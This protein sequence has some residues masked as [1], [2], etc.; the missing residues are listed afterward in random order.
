[1]NSC[2][3]LVIKLKELILLYDPEDC[4]GFNRL[5]KWRKAMISDGFPA[6]V[7]NDWCVAFLLTPLEDLTSRDVDAIVD[8]SSRSLQL[9]ASASQ[10]IAQT[11]FPKEGFEVKNG[12]GIKQGKIKERVRLARL[13]GEFINILRGRKPEENSKDAVV[14]DIVLDACSE[15]CSS[16]ED[17]GTKRNDLYK[18]HGLKLKSL[19]TE[20][21]GKRRSREDGKEIIQ[22]SVSTP[23]T[24]DGEL[25]VVKFVSRQTSYLH[26]NLPFVLSH[27]ELYAPMLML[28]RRWLSSIVTKPVLASHTLEIVE[29]LFSDPPSDSNSHFLEQV[30]GKIQERILSLPKNQSL[31]AQ[32]QAA[33]YN[34]ESKAELDLWSSPAVELPCYLSRRESP[35]ERLHTKKLTGVLR[36]LWYE[37]KDI[38]F[39]YLVPSVEVGGKEV[40]TKDLFGFQDSLKEMEEQVVAVKAKVEQINSV[41]V[42]SEDLERR[43]KRLI[44][45][46]QQH[47]KRIEKIYKTSSNRVSSRGLLHHA[48]HFFHAFAPENLPSMPALAIKEFFNIFTLCKIC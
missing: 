16:H 1:M 30:R 28:L 14:R 23:H 25:K 42:K 9:V 37:W 31:M 48:I 15:L 40:C 38:L 46:E 33:G 27:K 24:G 18:I 2:Q 26:E 10:V 11:L 44:R 21:F 34:Q 32:F 29:T 8:L 3:D 4:Y 36:R 47:R 20:I 12:E 7:I 45:L 35:S 13:L 19:F 43:V 41:G 17:R 22:D 5:P 39:M 6:R